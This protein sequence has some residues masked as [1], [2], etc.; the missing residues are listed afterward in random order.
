MD[1]KD[2]V[3]IMGDFNGRVGTRKPTWERYMG[4]HSDRE[5]DQNSNG[6][7]LLQ[8]CAEHDL[9]ISNTFFQHRRSQVK[10]WYKWNDLKTAS[11]IDFILAKRSK[12]RNIRDSRVIP[13]YI[14]DTDHRPVIMTIDTPNRKKG[15]KPGKDEKS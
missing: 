9:V 5:T 7:M 11:Q 3:T 13:N 14:I 15:Q 1:E 10:T 4:P 2:N 12:L 6:E 8:L